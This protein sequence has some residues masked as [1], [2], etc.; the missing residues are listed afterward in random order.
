MANCI[1]R[2]CESFDVNLD[3]KWELLNDY[4]CMQKTKTK[5]YEIKSLLRTT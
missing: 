2:G 5:E 1:C 3:N 4:L